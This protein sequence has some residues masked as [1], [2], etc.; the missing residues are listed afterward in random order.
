LLGDVKVFFQLLAGI[1]WTIF[2]SAQV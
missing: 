1:T 2:F